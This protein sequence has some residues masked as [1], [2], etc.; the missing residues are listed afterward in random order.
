[1][2]QRV[3][4]PILRPWMAALLGAGAAGFAGLLIAVRPSLGIAAV[5]AVFY[6][7]IAF[8]SL[9]VALIGWVPIPFVESLP[10]VW[11]G[12]TFALLLLLFAWVGTLP[13]QRRA[14]WPALRGHGRTVISL[15]LTLIWFAISLAWAPDPSRGTELILQYTIA[16]FVAII[17]IT[18][19]QEPRHARW[20]FI[21]FVV[22]ATLSVVAGFLVSGL[23][24]GSLD[25]DEEGRLS[26]G[27]GDP[28][29]LAAGLV[30][31]I[32]LAGAVFSRYRHPIG[33]IGIAFAV[34]IMMAGLVATQSRGGILSAIIAAV[35]ALVVL[36][37]HRAQVL[38]GL[39]I[40]ATVAGL[41]FAA[42]PSAWQRVTEYQGGGTGRTD[43]WRIALRVN[44]A[45]P[46]N[47]I[48]LGNFEAEAKLFVRRP[49][50]LTYV[51]L[52]VDKP[53]VAHNTYLQILA[54]TGVIGLLLWAS[55][56]LALMGATRRAG[57][58]LERARMPD[59]AMMA[60]ALLVAQIAMLAA[61]FFISDGFDKR[62]WVLLGLGAVL[63]GIARR[64]APK[65]P[66][67]A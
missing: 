50:Q 41:W 9:P 59:L 24:P 1:V 25:A 37:H 11:V 20:V 65:A 16:I 49:G 46:I 21:A 62:L 55:A 13:A 51:R 40:V 61:M 2:T 56:V 7:P 45:H 39:A 36:R 42:F 8:L 53:H 47:G 5:L 22:G 58:E 23:D 34:A 19:I 66:A 30:P 3:A 57:K 15:I 67:A 6:T 33:R 4:I 63:L 18:T 38:A 52:I 48:G 64:G 27:G 10:F 35:A 26:G 14:G 28:N 29:V 17:V 43:L 60:R 54:E 31:A 12:P 44:A 32:V